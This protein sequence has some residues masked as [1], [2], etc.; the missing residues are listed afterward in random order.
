MTVDNVKLKT[1]A[2]AILDTE[3]FHVVYSGFSDN[4]LYRAMAT[5][6]DDHLGRLKMLAKYE[7]YQEIYA[8]MKAYADYS[9]KKSDPLEVV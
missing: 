6:P 4:A 7:A 8:E 9:P 1:E 2:E 5:A 3:V